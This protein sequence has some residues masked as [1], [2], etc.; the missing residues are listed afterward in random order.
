MILLTLF[1]AGAAIFFVAHVLLL[2]TSFGKFDYSRTKY[3]WSHLT[4]WICGI[5]LFTATSMYAGKG[6]SPVLDVFD[7]R[8]KQLLI[9]GVVIVLSIAAH[10]IVK[11]LVMPKYQSR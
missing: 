11:L 7:T 4:L 2:F 6:V 3:L 5:L 8:V 9:P 1:V 10:T